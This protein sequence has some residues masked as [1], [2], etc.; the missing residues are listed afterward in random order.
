MPACSILI[1]PAS[2]ACNIA[3]RYC[4]YREIAAGRDRGRLAPMSAQTLETLIGEAFRYADGLVSFAWQGGEPMLAGLSFFQ[5]AIELE[6]SLAKETGVRFE[7][8]IQTNGLLIDD[9]WARFF[10]ENGFLVGLSLDGPREVNDRCRVD[11]SGRG[12][13]NRVI[14]AAGRLERQGVDFNIVS[15][16]TPAMAADPAGTYRFLR[17]RGFRFLQF[18]PCMSE[19]PGTGNP[20]AVRPLEYGRFLADVF[21]LWYAEYAAGADV[22]IRQFSNWA[23]MAAG[24]PAEECGMCGRCTTYFAVEADGS[25]YPCDFYTQDAWRLGSVGDGSDRLFHADASER[26]MASSVEKPAECLACPH[27]RLCRGGCRRW[28]DGVRTGAGDGLGV[29]YLCEGYRYFFERCGERIE[30]LGKLIRRNLM[31]MPAQGIL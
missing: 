28:R 9:A 29:N 16:V 6:R 8:T 13:F 11:R 24:L 27:Y 30:R 18:I 10:R 3:C 26:F 22:D 4:F 21:D 14:A 17:S 12:T 7:N 23:Q 15:V 1:K 5:R 20:Y 2:S 19:Q 25:V 31:G